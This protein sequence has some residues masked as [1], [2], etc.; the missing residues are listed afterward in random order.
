VVDEV[1]T[2]LPVVAHVQGPGTVSKIAT[3]TAKTD[4]IA[5]SSPS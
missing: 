3:K 4:I 5:R 1:G 2:K